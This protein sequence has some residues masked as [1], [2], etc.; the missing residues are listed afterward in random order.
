VPVVVAASP[1]GPAE[2]VDGVADGLDDEGDEQALDLVAG[3][4]YEGRRTRGCTHVR[5]GHHQDHKLL[6]GN[7]RGWRQSVRSSPGYR[8]AI[9]ACVSG[10]Q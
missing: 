1:V 3:E 7:Q 10:V 2:P 5:T 4:R 6:Q 8:S 9:P